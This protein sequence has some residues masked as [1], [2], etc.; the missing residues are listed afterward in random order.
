MPV[1]D[2]VNENTICQGDADCAEGSSC[3]A[4]Q[5]SEQG[6]SEQER[7]EQETLY[8]RTLGFAAAVC[9]VWNKGNGLEP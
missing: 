2:T 4:Q 6:G 8:G 5:G 9:M 1:T 3:P 7:I